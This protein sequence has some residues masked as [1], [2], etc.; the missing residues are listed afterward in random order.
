MLEDE[1]LFAQYQKMHKVGLIQM[2]L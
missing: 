2:L 1:E